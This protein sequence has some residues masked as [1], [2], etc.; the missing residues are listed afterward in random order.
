MLL[1]VLAASL[2]LVPAA[3]SATRVW[4]VG[5]GGVTGPTDDALAARVAREGI[6]RLLYLGDVYETGTPEEYRTLYHPSW[7][8]FKRI[9]H[10][11]PGNHEWGNR[12]V[13]YDPYWGKRAPRH[14]GGHYYSFNIGRWH[15]VSLNSHEDSG[16]RSSQAAWLTRDLKRY[17]G[18]CTIA[19]H[20]RARYTAGPHGDAPDLEPLYKRLAGRAVALL[21]GHDHNYQRLRPRRGITQF[22]VGSGGRELERVDTSDRRL[23]AFDFRSHGAL[24]MELRHGLLRYRFVRTN[25]TSRDVGSRRCRPH[26]RR[27]SP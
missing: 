25:G 15:F 20:H 5:D 19:F 7:G 9:T 8:R 13:G 26:P 14:R 18:T 23:A 16:P 3:G 11:T 12:S 10:P 17:R 2:V 6:D 21:S 27:T 22:I 1:V 24:R 4:A